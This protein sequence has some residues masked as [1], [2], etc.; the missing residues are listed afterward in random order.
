MLLNKCPYKN[1]QRTNQLYNDFTIDISKYTPGITEREFKQKLVANGFVVLLNAIPVSEIDAMRATLISTYEKAEKDDSLNDVEK[2]NIR[3]SHISEKV[4]KQFNPGKS[5]FDVFN[6][7]LCDLGKYFF[8]GKFYINEAT[9]TRRVKPPQL[10][11]LKY[12][13]SPIGIHIDAMYHPPIEFV[14]NF[15]TPL[16]DSGLDKPTLRAF[17]SSLDHTFSLMQFDVRTLK[18]NPV[19]Y[20]QVQQGTAPFLQDLASYY[21]VVN[22]GDIVAISN[23][24]FHAGY[25]NENMKYPRWSMELRISGTQFWYSR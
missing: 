10:L 11:D 12:Y 2:Q 1:Y 20:E 21:F 13:Q 16:E 8:S 17:L 15:W 25:A 6:N 14:I 5:L 18:F 3:S 4:F 19:I 22:K 9:H 24:T 23:W 7:K